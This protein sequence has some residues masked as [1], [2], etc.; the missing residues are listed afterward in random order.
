[1]G[2]KIII[3]NK[4][5]ALSPQ[6]KFNLKQCVFLKFTII[7]ILIALNNIDY[8]LKGFYSN[9]RLNKNLG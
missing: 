2:I 7:R 9:R 6:T 1:M 8:V 4:H 5:E 3:K